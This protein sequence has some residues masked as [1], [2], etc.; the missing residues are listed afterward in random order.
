MT[1][2]GNVSFI[3]DIYLLTSCSR[4]LLEK[5]T[6]F[7]LV[8]KFP[9]FYGTRRFITAFTSALHLY[10]SWASSNESIPSHLTSWRSILILSSH[11]RLGIPSCLFSFRFP[12]KTLYTNLL[13]TIRATCLAHLI[14]LDFITRTK[15]Y[16]PVAGFEPAIPASERLETHAL[17]GA[18]TGIWRCFTR[19]VKFR[20]VLCCSYCER[21]EII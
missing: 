19:F 6:C 7:Q 20:G 11:L 13:S 15:T 21:K 8:K 4:V 2:R 12:T 9:A 18:A 17:E 3:R 1:Y 14:L 16:M 5:L 10:L